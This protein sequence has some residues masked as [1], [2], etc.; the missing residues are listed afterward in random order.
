VV[1]G[2]YRLEDGTKVRVEEGNQPAGSA[3]AP[4]R[5]NQPGAGA[6]TNRPSTNQLPQQAG[7]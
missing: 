5:V 7:A 6:A 4:G 3:A 1:D 2:Q